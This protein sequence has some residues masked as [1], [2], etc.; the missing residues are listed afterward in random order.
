MLDDTGYGPSLRRRCS[1]N[2]LTHTVLAVLGP[3]WLLAFYHP[4]SGNSGISLPGSGAVPAP[5][6]A[7][8]LA[9]GERAIVTKVKPGLVIINTALQFDSEA[10]VGTGMVINADGLVLTNNHVIDD[11]TKITAT[12]AAAGR[13]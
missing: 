6:P 7:A 4:G 8:P 2:V 5:A 3:R 1:G 12:V 13:T 9:G 11:S 10:A